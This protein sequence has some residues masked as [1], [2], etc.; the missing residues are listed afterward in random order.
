[1][2]FLNK[3]LSD[4]LWL[5]VLSIVSEVPTG[6]QKLGMAFA[7]D[8]MHSV[9]SRAQTSAIDECIV[10]LLRCVYQTEPGPRFS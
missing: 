6:L 2:E 8:S 9:I 5:L 4:R 10:D 3:L 7:G 1:M